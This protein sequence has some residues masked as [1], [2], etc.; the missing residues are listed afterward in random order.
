VET[1]FVE[2]ASHCGA[3]GHDPQEYIRVLQQFLARH[4]GSD[5]PRGLVI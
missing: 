1:Y 5:F 3:Y 2:E 4:L